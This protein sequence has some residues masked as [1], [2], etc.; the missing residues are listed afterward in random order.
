MLS[1]TIDGRPRAAYPR[2][3]RPATAGLAT[4]AQLRVRRALNT[5]PACP[6]RTLHGAFFRHALRT[7]YAA[8][9]RFGDGGTLT[10][11]ELAV[12]A[13][14]AAARL[15]AR[16]VRPG[17]RVALTLPPGPQHAVAVLAVLSA[18]ATY[19]PLSPGGLRVVEAIGEGSAVFVESGEPARPVGVAAESTAY[20]A[21][22][23]GRGGAPK[24]VEVSHRAAA[25][26]VDA[27]VERYGMDD[28]D[29]TF[30]ASPLSSD[31]SVFE[32][33]AA[34]TVGGSVVLP[35]ADATAARHAELAARWGVTV[36]NGVPSVL[37][38]LL[39]QDR[40]LPMLRL[41]LLGR[42]EFRPG[43]PGRAA[44]R[45]PGCLLAR[46]GGATE[47]ALY[48]TVSEYLGRPGTVPYGV[49]LRGTACRVVDGRGLDRPDG[50]A[51]ELWIGGACLA[52]GY[53]D[54]TVATAAAFP[55]RDGIR[56]HRTGDVARYRPGGALEFLGRATPP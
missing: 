52:E 28:T 42:A 16:G 39:A 27:L 37:E 2:P 17:D 12:R 51:G 9:V 26:T 4:P 15:T 49:P 6:P 3:G 32:L 11:G 34:W 13:L 47:T 25:N 30:A 38:G 33:F 18:G 20:V 46:L 22:T 21:F 14:R 24:A 41:A 7:P 44:R 50:V 43:L 40:P 5:R 23:A 54:D 35:E 53:A 48:A 31:L 1:E 55:V 19:T 45:L 8:A 29:V 36:L 56:W 10:Y